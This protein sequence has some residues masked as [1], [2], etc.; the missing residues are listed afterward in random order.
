MPELPEVE[1]V[2]RSLRQ[3]I[4]GRTISG[5]DVFAPQLF[6]E[7]KLFSSFGRLVSGDSV[8]SMDRRGKYLLFYLASRRVMVAHMKMTGVFRVLTGTIDQSIVPVRFVRFQM[9]FADGAILLFSDIRKF[10][11]IWLVQEARLDDFFN[12]RRIGHDALSKLCTEKYFKM[13]ISNDRRIKALLLDQTCVAGIGN[14]YADEM[15]WYSKIHPLKKGR[16]LTEREARA[17]YKAMGRVLA[18]GIRAGGASVSDFLRP[19]GSPGYFQTKRKVYKR[20]G[21]PCA[22]CKTPIKRIVVGQRSAH[23]CPHCQRLA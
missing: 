22:R 1:T 8:V 3:T 6:E 11:R 7:K 20:E 17:L 10:G 4:I 23:F 16:D 9:N 15:L 14:I 5:A 2:V 13:Q 18:M 19:D 12:N 21:K